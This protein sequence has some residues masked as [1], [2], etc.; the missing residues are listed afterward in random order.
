MTV[1]AVAGIAPDPLPDPGRITDP[2]G[3]ALP[4]QEE[5]DMSVL[6]LP[7]LPAA[8]VR[9]LRPVPA[10][11]SPAAEPDADDAVTVT[12]RVGSGADPRSDRVLAALREL[13]AAAGEDPELVPAAGAARPAAPVELRIDPRPR[14]VHRGGR[15]LLLSRLEFDLLLF[16]ARH[17][18]RVFTRS[19]LMQQVWGHGHTG[20]RTVDVHVSRLRSK[21]GGRPDVITTVYGVGYRLA[22]DAGVVVAAA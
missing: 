9:P 5:I 19:Q 8:R 20:V 17:P 22:D 7:A 16:L 13:I 1:S 11:G 15:A 18:R 21:L 12:V 10:D 4:H 6:T 3:A 2:A 14:T